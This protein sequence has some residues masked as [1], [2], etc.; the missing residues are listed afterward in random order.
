[1]TAVRAPGTDPAVARLERALTLVL[2]LTVLDCAY[3]SWRYLALKAG[4]VTPGTGLCSWTTWIDCD[5]V[6]S[7]PEARA[8]FVP[9]ALLGFGFFFGCLLWWT[10]GRRALDPRL[11]HHLV[12]TLAVWLVIASGFTL[13]FWW[14]LVH[15]DHLCPFC[16]WN[17]LWT[18]VATAVALTLWRRT[19]RPTDPAPLAPLLALVALCV[20]QFFLWLAAW[21]LALQQGLLSP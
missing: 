9:N 2:T 3:L 10:I 4:A 19:P 20:G 13:R 21:W 18:W 17:H 16:P 5:Q 12:R 11:R 8:F 15:L 1:M 6:L 14:L 7:T